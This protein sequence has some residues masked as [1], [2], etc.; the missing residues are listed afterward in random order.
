MID[1]AKNKA[2]D[3]PS[4][5]VTIQAVSVIKNRYHFAGEG[6]YHPISVVATTIEEAT[7]LWT[8]TR[9]PI[10]VAATANSQETASV[11]GDTEQLAT[12]A[13]VNVEE[14]VE[15]QNQASNQ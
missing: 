1:K 13:P 10:A 6:L 15:E 9:V 2:L 14:K 7:D 5:R 11:T 3:N 4:A 12:E 8:R